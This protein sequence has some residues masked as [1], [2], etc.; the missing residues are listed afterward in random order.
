MVY[1]EGFDIVFNRNKSLK[2]D[3]SYFVF[4]KYGLNKEASSSI[5]SKWVSYC[6]STLIGWYYIEDYWGCM[7]GFKLGVNKDE[8]TNGEA[9]NKLNVVEGEIS[10]RDSN[11]ES[12]FTQQ[13]YYMDESSRN[14]EK[15]EADTIDV[16]S[17]MSSSSSAGVSGK[18]NL[19]KETTFLETK[20]ESELTDK[21]NMVL[22]SSSTF[23]YNSKLV[24]AINSENLLFK[25]H[26][27]EQFSKMSFKELNKF[28]GRQKRVKNKRSTYKERFGLGSNKFSDLGS[29]IQ[30]NSNKLKISR[31]S[32][33]DIDI[34]DIPEYF[35]WADKMSTARSQVKLIIN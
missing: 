25:A 34:N 15:V 21:N 13:R 4:S 30:Q 3:R 9:Q 29:F 14:G 32:D 6:Y 1:D 2:N 17:S 7:Y 11:N 31:E 24:N 18:N 19:K 20:F 22:T 12:T 33:K 35:T 8:V 27:Y 5:K 23:M 26:N 10:N 16:I 28:A